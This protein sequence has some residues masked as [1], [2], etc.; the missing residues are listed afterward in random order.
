MN[1][2]LKC[3]LETLTIKLK[4]AMKPASF[5]FKNAIVN[6]LTLTI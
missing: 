1:S 3:K 2:S 4:W 5:N 6:P